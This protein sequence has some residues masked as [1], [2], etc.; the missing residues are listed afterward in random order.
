MVREPDSILARSSCACVCVRTVGS[1]GRCGGE[2]N[3]LV[4]DN[5]QV[6][7]HSTREPG[8]RNKPV[9]VHS[10]RAGNSWVELGRIN[11]RQQIAA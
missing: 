6:P 11:R 8:R 3:R 4:A 7:E 5:T 9:P 10:R 2:D 1:T